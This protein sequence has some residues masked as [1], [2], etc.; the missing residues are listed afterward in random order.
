[1]PCC[2]FTLLTVLQYLEGS[3]ENQ[4]G[5]ERGPTISQING[6]TDGSFHSQLSK[7]RYR[8]SGFSDVCTYVLLALTLLLSCCESRSL[9]QPTQ[10]SGFTVRS[11]LELQ[12]ALSAGERFIK[13]AEHLSLTELQGG[14]IVVG[15]SSGSVAIWVRA[16]LTFSTQIGVQTV[17]TS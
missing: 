9:L 3:L 14:Q 1:M 17:S 2:S 11:A 4:A 12:N 10:I 8:R 5:P 16:S 13:V 15:N 6:A 7:T